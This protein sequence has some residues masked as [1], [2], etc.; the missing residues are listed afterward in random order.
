MIDRAVVLARLQE[1]DQSD[2]QHLRLCDA[3][4]LLCDVAVVDRMDMAV[5]R[6]PLPAVVLSGAS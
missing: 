6:E 1:A 5:D 4:L 2:R 3:V